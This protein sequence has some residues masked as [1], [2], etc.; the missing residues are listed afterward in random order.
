MLGVGW[1]EMLVIGIVAL[2]FIGPKDLPV[3]MRQIG[4]YAGMIRRMGS[5]F[6]REINKTTGLDEVR[7]LRNS[8][9]A[10]LKQTTDE[11]RREFNALSTT[12]TVTPSG[13][14]KPAD[15]KAESVVDEIKS[16]AGLA[17][18]KLDTAEPAA[19]PVVVAKGPVKAKRPAKA[20]PA[21]TAPVTAIDLADVSPKEI[22]LPTAARAEPAK[23]ASV[24]AEK[25]KPAAKPKAA[26]KK[27]PAEKVARVKAVATTAEKP[28]A[29][30]AA[31]KPRAPAR[32][33]A[34]KA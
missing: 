13:A 24:A 33:K 25:A 22:P 19:P 29:P 17:Q 21:P 26:I 31:P 12:G 20:N 5:E 28:A 9:T 2:I 8:I 18:P 10:P 27:E 11:I 16:A 34:D 15:P 30:K 3:V 4:R 23:S 14:I 6:Q 32:A 1:T 7:N